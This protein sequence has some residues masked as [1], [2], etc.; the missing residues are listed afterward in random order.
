MTTI[1]AADIDAYQRD[2]AVLLKG[3]LPK[4]RLALLEAGLEEANRDRGAMSSTVQNSAGTG[5][6]LV[7]QF[8]SQ[9]SNAL[10]ELLA[11]D[12]IGGI[13]GQMLG[14]QS[15]QLILDQVFYKQAGEI[16]PTPWHQD[17]GYLQVR[18]HDMLRVW[19]T[20]DFSPRALTVQ[21]VRGSHRWNVV[22]DTRLVGEVDIAT[23]EEGDGFTYDSIVGDALLPALPD[24]ARH[25]D[26]FDI[27]SWDVEPGDILIFNGNM[28][29]GTEGV[30]RHNHPRRAFT[31]MWGGPELQYYK[32]RIGA[33]IPTPSGDSRPIADGTPIRQL[34]HLFPVGWR[35]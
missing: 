10:R 25:R 14:T 34:E 8:P 29:H 31:S 2:G 5:E 30:A 13:A 28:L 19:L 22:Y 20:C 23:V 4:A 35:G 26:S 21:V 18:G 7:E 17:T 33:A 16:V 3:A 6:T 24:I 9:R 15:A 11:D 27:L 12:F 1:S 32:P